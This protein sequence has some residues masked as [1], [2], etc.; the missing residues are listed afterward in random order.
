M[1]LGDVGDTDIHKQHDAAMT[2]MT[3]CLFITS[4][5]KVTMHRSQQYNQS[6][7]QET[8]LSP[9]NTCWLFNTVTMHDFG[10]VLLLQT[11]HKNERWKRHRLLLVTS[12]QGTIYHQTCSSFLPYYGRLRF[13]LIAS[14]WG[15][16]KNE[17][18]KRPRLFW[19][20]NWQGTNPHQ[21]C[22]WTSS[23]FLHY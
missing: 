3:A 18:W 1:L 2:E 13:N 17:R 8:W 19:V 16:K 5:D 21:P 14:D 4:R 23:S 11:E 22:I 10:L 15:R 20:P 12:W 7:K 6:I 9:L